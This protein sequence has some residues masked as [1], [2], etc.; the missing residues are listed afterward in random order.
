VDKGTNDRVPRQSVGR[1]E[2]MGKKISGLIKQAKIKE[3]DDIRRV[4]MHDDISSISLA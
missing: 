4:K 1:K 3:R 2:G